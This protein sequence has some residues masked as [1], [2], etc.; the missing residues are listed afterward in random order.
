MKT[1]WFLMLATSFVLVAMQSFVLRENTRVLREATLELRVQRQ[2]V[3]RRTAHVCR[4]VREEVEVW[5][6]Y[7]DRRT[8]LMLR[9][10]DNEGETLIF[11]H[12]QLL[13]LI[14]LCTTTELGR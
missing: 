5:D 11:D 14:N 4:R 1:A 7:Q 12:D 8:Q 10:A 3:Q 9:M 6:Y 13:E 2:R